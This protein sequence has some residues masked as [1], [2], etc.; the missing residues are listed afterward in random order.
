MRSFL[1]PGFA[2]ALLPL[3]AF[4]FEVLG[5]ISPL[6]FSTLP[7]ATMTV[8]FGLDTPCP[9]PRLKPHVCGLLRYASLHALFSLPLS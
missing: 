5:M 8:L 2:V 3:P 6:R 4:G 9:L 1:Q 7:R